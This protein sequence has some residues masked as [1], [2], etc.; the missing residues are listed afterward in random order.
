MPKS[1]TKP[2]RL[3]VLVY[4][5]SSL[6][7]AAGEQN[8]CSPPPIRTDAL[9]NPSKH[10]WDLFLTLNHPAVDKQVERG[11][12]DCGK[13]IGSPGTTSVWETWRNA[14][15]EV[16]L[17]GGVEPPDWNDTK[18]PDEKPGQVPADPKRSA[19]ASFHELAFRNVN[20]KAIKPQFSPGDGVFDNK[21]GGFGETRMNR[22]TY[23]FIRN[24]CLF[25]A[26][27]LIRYAKAVE[28]NK[29]PPI[30]L[31]VDSIEVKAA[32]LALEDPAHPVK[33]ANTYYTAQYQGKKYGLVAWHLLTKDT[34]NWFWASFHHK[35]TPDNKEN[36]IPD[37]YGRPK[38]LNGTI[39]E[40][41]LLGGAQIDFIKTTGE[42]TRLSDFYVEFN[43]QRSSCMTCHATAATS[44][45]GPMPSGLG[46]TL[47]LC[48]MAPE[49]VKGGVVRC[50][51]LLGES[52]FNANTG[53]LLVERGVPDPNWFKK[54]GLQYY[55][56]TDFLYSMPFR[57]QD[58]SAAPPARCVW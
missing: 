3:L 8:F 29:K 17:D 33:N 26:Q 20:S 31:P 46:Q 28:Q 38:E 6:N 25:S 16:F 41:Y 11:K 45:T 36:E 7:L 32:W 49:Q 39:W 24:Q 54:N 34:P 55:Q 47:A 57:A 30:Q 53:K 13:P 42:A 9:D 1:L 52:A 14:N 40:N 12:A 51:Q 4:A 10:A 2:V 18:Y 5:I 58:E 37:T 43:F 27:G 50:K 15:S 48:S 35:D 44:D 23:E 56:Q 22:I 19:V 21:N